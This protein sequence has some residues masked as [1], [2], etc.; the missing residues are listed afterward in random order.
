MQEY[1]FEIPELG[2]VATQS[3]SLQLGDLTDRALENRA[4]YVA[5]QTSL[6]ATEQSVKVAQ[7]TRWPS[8]R[9]SP[10]SAS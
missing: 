9:T 6:R 10:E 8:M 7:A 5:A 3:A 2:E 1:T 4:D